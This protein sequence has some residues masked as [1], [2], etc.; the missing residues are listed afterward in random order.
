MSGVW[1]RPLKVGKVGHYLI[2]EDPK[3]IE[4]AA[5]NFAEATADPSKVRV[6]STEYS[7]NSITVLLEGIAPGLH[8]VK[9]D[10]RTT[11]GSSD[12]YR[13]VVKV[14]NCS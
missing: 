13:G 3:W 1:P 10:Y 4:G 9:V 5:V 11:A 6:I 12:C 2:F 8:S 7:D 14:V